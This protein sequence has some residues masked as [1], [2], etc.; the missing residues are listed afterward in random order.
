MATVARPGKSLTV[1][2]IMFKDVTNECKKKG[3]FAETLNYKVNPSLY[4][5][6]VPEG[7][8]DRNNSMNCRISITTEEQ[9]H[10]TVSVIS[11]AILHL[12]LS[13]KTNNETV[14][15]TT[16][17]NNTARSTTVTVPAACDNYW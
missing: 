1:E 8:H 9:T 12:Q 14:R 15:V 16:I 2:H 11:L 5:K 10:R 4:M 6:L 7:G 17:G 3:L 13:G